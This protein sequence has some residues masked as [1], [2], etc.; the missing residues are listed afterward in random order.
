MIDLH[1]TGLRF[2]MFDLDSLSKCVVQSSN[3]GFLSR[4]KKID[5]KLWKTK[6]AF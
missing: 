1:S 6:T 4:L 2:V 5:R 3:V